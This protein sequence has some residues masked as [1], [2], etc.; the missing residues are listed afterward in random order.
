M[1]GQMFDQFDQIW[2]D[3]WDTIYCGSCG[4]FMG[5]SEA[6]IDD[7]EFLCP[8]CFREDD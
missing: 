5:Y 6:E 2:S 8:C 7:I 1:S 4:E 3:D